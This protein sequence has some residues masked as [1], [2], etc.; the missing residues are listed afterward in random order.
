MRALELTNIVSNEHDSA[1]PEEASALTNSEPI[2]F[3]NI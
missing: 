3:K 2:L 1:S